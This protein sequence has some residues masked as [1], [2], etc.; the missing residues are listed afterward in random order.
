[1]FAA[2]EELVDLYRS[3]GRHA[4]EL[5]QLQAL[6]SFDRQRPERQV[7]LASAYTRAARDARDLAAQDR[8]TNLA[9]L[10]LTSALERA[11]DHPIVFST[12][13]EV[14]LDVARSRDDA[15][16]LRKALEMLR[17]AAS[18][19]SSGSDAFLAYGRALVLDNQLEASLSAL[20]EATERFPVNP[21][22]FLDYAAVAEQTNQLAIAQKA[23]MA[24]AAL[25]AGAPDSAARAA[26]IGLLSLRLEEPSTAILWLQRALASEPT[27]LDYVAAL[28]DAQLRNLQPDDARAT[29]ARGLALDPRNAHLLAF[30]RKLRSS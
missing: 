19:S 15:V 2:R 6:G 22:A 20:R 9:I 8:L 14:W 5:E 10:T 7:A 27:N 28:A 1:M 17:R 13:G 30:A 11:P 3:L 25:V 12:L 24:H 23:L 29:A 18:S 4:D 26:R 16:A 21:A